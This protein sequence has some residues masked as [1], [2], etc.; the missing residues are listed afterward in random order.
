MD[1]I[2]AKRVRSLTRM[3][4]FP[5]VGEFELKELQSPMEA[6]LAR[7]GEDGK[8]CWACQR[9]DGILWSDGRWRITLTQPTANPVGL[10]LETVDHIDFHDFGADMASEFGLLAWRLEAAI[11]SLDSVG[12]VH[13]H[14]W[15]DGSS[16][17]HVWFQGR[18]AR[19]LEMYGWGDVLWTQLLPPLDQDVIDSN[20][21]RVIAAFTCLDS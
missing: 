10:F 13:I 17:F 7:D 21:A 5:F 6:E 11:N 20:H 12:R 14:R 18:P 9:T 16:H 8:L 1:E 3:P 15:G 4:L 2:V 19:Q